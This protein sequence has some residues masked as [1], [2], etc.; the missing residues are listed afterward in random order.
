MATSL[1]DVAEAIGAVLTIPGAVVAL[2]FVVLGWRKLT[3]QPL[4]R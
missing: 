4:Y 1:L 2:G 3:G